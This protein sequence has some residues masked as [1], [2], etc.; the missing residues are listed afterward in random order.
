LHRPQDTLLPD[1]ARQ[2]LRETLETLHEV[3]RALI[4]LRCPFPMVWDP[5]TLIPTSSADGRA[6][7][8]GN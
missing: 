5:S 2:R 8:G 7:G 6:G 3:E 1:C 4:A